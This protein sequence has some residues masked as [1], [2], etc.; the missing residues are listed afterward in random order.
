[1]YA[2]LC[3]CVRVHA[4]WFLR[5]LVYFCP[6]S[7]LGIVFPDFFPFTVLSL[8]FF[9]TPPP[10]YMCGVLQS[11]APTGLSSGTC[12][13]YMG[14]VGPAFFLTAPPPRH[15]SLIRFLDTAEPPKCQRKPLA[16]TWRW[17]F[18][19]SWLRDSGHMSFILLYSSVAGWCLSEDDYCA[20]YL[21]IWREFEES[22]EL[23]YV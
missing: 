8:C 2:L 9:P 4:H 10:P 7:F 16:E 22:F 17:T 23:E 19:L 11:R 13:P 20:E 1:M 6:F 21:F 15:L 14:L 5:A 3:T 12:V 18:M